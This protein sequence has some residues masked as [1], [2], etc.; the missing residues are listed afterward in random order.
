[1]ARA[2]LSPARK[3]LAMGS[4]SLRKPRAR[5]L[6]VIRATAAARGP[7]KSVGC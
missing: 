1:M 7:R 6:D 4:R 3:C 5:N 2:A